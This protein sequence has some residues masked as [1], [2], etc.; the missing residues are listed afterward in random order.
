MVTVRGA[1]VAVYEANSESVGSFGHRDERPL[2]IVLFLQGLGFSGVDWQSTWRQLLRRSFHLPYRLRCLAVDSPGIWRSAPLVEPRPWTL[3]D[4]ADWLIELLEACGITP[5]DDLTVFGNSFGAAKAIMMADRYPHWV[6]RLI[7]TESMLAELGWAQKYQPADAL[8]LPD[9]DRT[10]EVWPD[11]VPLDWPGII[12]EQQQPDPLPEH[13][14]AVSLIRQHGSEPPGEPAST[15]DMWAQA[16]LAEAQCRGIPL[17]YEPY[18]HPLYRPDFE[19]VDR[20]GQLRTGGP[21]F[22]AE[23]V[24]RMLTAAPGADV[25]LAGFLA[26]WNA[27]NKP[28]GPGAPP[29]FGMM[30]DPRRDQR[31]YY[32]LRLGE[33][34]PEFPGL[35]GEHDPRQ[36]PNDVELWACGLMCPVQPVDLAVAARTD[37]GHRGYLIR[38]MSAL[39]DAADPVRLGVHLQLNPEL[40]TFVCA[41]QATD[42]P[43]YPPNVLCVPQQA[44]GVQSW[45]PVLD[46]LTGYGEWSLAAWDDFGW[47]DSDPLPAGVQLSFSDWRDVLQ[48]VLVGLPPAPTVLVG[49]GL[50]GTA[51]LYAVLRNAREPI[52]GEEQ[53]LVGAVAISPIWPDAMIEL[54]ADPWAGSGYDLPTMVRQWASVSA[55]PPAPPG[56]PAL[57]VYL[58]AAVSWARDPATSQLLHSSARRHATEIGADVRTRIDRYPATHHA[59]AVWLA[60]IIAGVVRNATAGYDGIAGQRRLA[61]R[62]PAGARRRHPR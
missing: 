1:D 30:Y 39:F 28:R 37:G 56:G 26:D 55:M 7:A 4:W 54:A 31:S 35:G 14:S 34:F 19:Y 20:N 22:A 60:G 58:P 5:D 9:P 6:N 52:Y 16:H 51:A 15:A 57:A 24:A 25:D 27:V 53:P 59:G 38:D 43:T 3:T 17:G 10:L 62:Q 32:H 23:L 42:P 61:P 12:R 29:E 33:L 11:A 50:A 44:V 2:R 47:G 49:H 45:I 41:P 40:S 36:A 46:Q 48:Q 13:I 21:A 18:V 8:H